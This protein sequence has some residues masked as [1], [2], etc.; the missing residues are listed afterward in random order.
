MRKV[1]V[2][3]KHTAF[4][5]RSSDPR[6]MG[7]VEA[8][9][10]AVA[11]MRPAHDDHMETVDEVLS[12]IQVLG[13]NF[14]VHHG[15]H[16]TFLP[17]DDVD[18]I[19]TVGG[20]GTFLAASH[21]VDRTPVLGINSAPQHSSGFFCAGRKGLVR[22]TLG[23][24]AEGTIARKAVLRMRVNINGEPFSDRV[25]NEALVCDVCPAAT[26]RYL[27]THLTQDITRYGQPLTE[28]HR[29][30]GLWV[31]TPAGSTGA[32]ASAG[33][34]I[35]DLDQR[36]LQFVVREP[37]Q[38][39]GTTIELHRGTFEKELTVISKMAE[40]RIYLDGSHEVLNFTI[41]DRL[42]FEPSPHPLTILGIA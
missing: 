16:S 38:P 32:L 15:A 21:L 8:G 6:I 14:E 41:A 42:T 10:P 3:V 33:G 26:S 4:E 30:S 11:R 12:E 22:A 1:I 28:E 25:L 29:S 40:G 37:Y 9:D 34:V 23:A 17:S 24:L 35:H 7:L 18:A 19:I 5:N 2:I 31:G 27:I 20:D 13:F 39:R 36:C